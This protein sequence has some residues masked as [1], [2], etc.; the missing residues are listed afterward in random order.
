MSS[1]T[2]SKKQHQD[3][4]SEDETEMEEEFPELT[5]IKR[6]KS[7]EKTKLLQKQAIKIS[8]QDKEIAD[9]QKKLAQ[10]KKSKSIPVLQV[11]VRETPAVSKMSPEERRWYRDI[12]DANKRFNWVKVKFCNTETKLV[13]LTSNI[14]DQWNLKEFEGLAEKELREAKIKWVAQNK[15]LVRLAMNDVRNYAQSQLRGLIVDRQVKNQW[16]PT[17]AQVKACALRDP[18]FHTDPNNQKIFDFYHDELIFRIV[19]KDHWDTW[20]RYYKTIQPSITVN[21]EAFLVALY[22]NCWI[23]WDMLVEKKKAGE[24]KDKT[25]SD[26]RY[27][28]N[29]ISTEL[30]QSRWGGWKPVGRDAVK[31]LCAQIQ[32]ARGKEHVQEMEQACL[33]RVRKANDI[34]QEDGDGK[35][36]KKRAV[37]EVWVNN[38]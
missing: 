29:Y 10:A 14:F 37:G 4:E 13:K 35:K 26:P 31:D 18:T 33:Q 28:T 30:G 3:H 12:C 27:K 5:D 9:L 36:D 11:T 21:T 8:N 19:G 6:M 34:D 25:R 1:S 22:E 17:P 32:E 20:T 16:V 38:K 15:E 7:G 24:K 23:K 2:R